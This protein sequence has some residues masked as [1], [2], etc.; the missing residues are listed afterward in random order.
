M[1][2]ARVTATVPCPCRLAIRHEGRFVIAYLAMVDTMEDAMPMGTLHEDLASV[3]EIFDA[4]N[5]LMRD[6]LAETVFRITGLRPVFR[7]GS[8][9]PAPEHERSGHG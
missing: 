6:C 4:W 1:S 9:Q 8:E 5:A 2:G 3:P 7:P